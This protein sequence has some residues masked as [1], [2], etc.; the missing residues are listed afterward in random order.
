MLATIQ[1]RILREE[2][3]L[4]AFKNIVLRGIFGSKREKVM[5]GWKKL[6]N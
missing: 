2:Q 1:F 6:N 3:R 5:G 4:R